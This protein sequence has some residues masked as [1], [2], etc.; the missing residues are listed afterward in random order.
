[1]MVIFKKIQR[2]NLIQIYT[3]TQE[4][5]SLKKKFLRTCLQTTGKA[6]YEVS[7]FSENIT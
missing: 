6:A 2:L 5:A 1:M 4:I 3:K 7:D